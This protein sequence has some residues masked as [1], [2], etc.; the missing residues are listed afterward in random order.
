MMKVFDCQDMPEDIKKAFF[1]C[2]EFASNDCYVSWHHDIYHENVDETNE[3]LEDNED[4]K[5]ET[6]YMKSFIK[7]SKLVHDWLIENGMEEIDDKV[8]IQYWW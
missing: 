5:E 7:N 3:E 1:A 8:L 6:D 4:L 2:N